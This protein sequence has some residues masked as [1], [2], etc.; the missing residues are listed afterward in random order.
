MAPLLA[1]LG[2]TLERVRG[3]ITFLNIKQEPP[4][5]YGEHRLPS[6]EHPL[7]FLTPR[8]RKAFTLASYECSFCRRKSEMVER[9]FPSAEGFPQ[10][11]SAPAPA[12]ICDIKSG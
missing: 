2:V 1:Q 11:G 4:F 9:I 10:L 3:G 8:A 12:F 5:L 7:L 6:G